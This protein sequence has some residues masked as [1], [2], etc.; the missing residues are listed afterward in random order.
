MHAILLHEQ[1][2]LDD[3]DLLRYAKQ[4][5]LDLDLYKRDRVSATVLDRVDRDVESGIASGEALGTPTLFI[6][7]AVYRGAYD[8]EA[9]LGVLT[10]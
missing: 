10:T 2:A 1:T 9:L 8:A 6:E 3:D 4:L 5:G 7:G